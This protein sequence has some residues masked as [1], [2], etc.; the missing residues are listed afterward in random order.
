M[1]YPQGNYEDSLPP[2]L[3]RRVHAHRPGPLTLWR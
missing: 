3:R 2:P 1:S